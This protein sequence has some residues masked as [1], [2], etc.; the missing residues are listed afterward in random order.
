[1]ITRVR[2]YSNV[3]PVFVL[4]QCLDALTTLIFLN[5]GVA[6]GNPLVGW[7]LPHA[8]AP[9][10]GLLTAKLVATALGVYCYRN[11][12]FTTLRLAN[13]GYT[14]IVAWNLLAIAAALVM[15]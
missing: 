11:G 2:T 3:L 12:R 15:R 5:K 1:M 7:A 13:V 14:A 4:L 8:H 10:I 9:W 6:E